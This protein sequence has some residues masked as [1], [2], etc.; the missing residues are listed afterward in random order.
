MSNDADTN[1]DALDR[2]RNRQRPTVPNRDVSLNSRSPDISISRNRDS[3]IPDISASGDSETFQ[4]TDPEKPV[5]EETQPP[6]PKE[7]SNKRYPDIETSTV[8]DIERL[9][10]KQSTLR[11]EA[12]LSDRL[13][14]LCRSQGIC[15]EVLLEALFEHF[16]SNLDVQPEILAAAQSKNEHRQHIA[17]LKRAQSMMK[18]F[19][20]R[21]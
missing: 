7:S 1:S 19:S 2:L 18:R 8:P 16:E 12:D 15:R 5:M 17:N 13:Q 9:D 14:T 3:Q 4:E 11:L 21:S 10:T 6:R 20:G